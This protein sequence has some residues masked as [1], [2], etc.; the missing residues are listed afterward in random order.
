RTLGAA[1]LEEGHLHMAAVPVDVGAVLAEVCERQRQ[2]S[3]EFDVALDVAADLP[4]LDADPR[5]LEQVFANLLSNAVKYSGASRSVRVSARGRG[6]RAEVAFADM[7]V[8][9]DADDLPRLFTRFFRARTSAGLPGTGIGLHLARELVRMHGGDMEVES[10]AG[11]GSTFRVLLPACA[12]LRG[13][14]AAE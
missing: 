10:I 2:I 11:R 12:A 1:R 4:A 14:A 8:G 6:D 3:P 7:G 9:I 13:R 5:L